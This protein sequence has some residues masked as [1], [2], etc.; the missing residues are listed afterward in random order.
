M[1]GPLIG[2]AGA[3]SVGG[4]L[5]AMLAHKGARVAFLGRRTFVDDATEFG[6]TATNFDGRLA[7]VPAA[8][9]VASDDPAILAGAD[10][11]LVTV[12][13]GDTEEMAET[14]A[15]T[16]S[17]HATLVSFQNG[18]GNGRILQRALPEHRVYR[19]SVPY[20]VISLG[21][22]QYRRAS[23]GN[24]VLDHGAS[25]IAPILR[26]AGA[27][28]LTADIEGVLWGKLLMNLNNALNALADA[29]LQEQLSNQAWRTRL[30]QMQNEA[31]LAMR[32]GGIVPKAP[33]ALP[34]R[35]F[36]A[37]LRLPTALFKLVAGRTITID[38][39]AR[40]SMWED[41][42]KGRATE[43]DALQ[44]EVIRLAE[45]AGTNADVCRAVVAAIKKA[46]N[47][48]AG[49]PGLSPSDI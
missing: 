4:Y 27:V 22:G 40:S 5:G 37:I 12:K 13:S 1:D 24:I 20:N 39:S 9:V 31:L 14:L 26:L 45:Q 44:G 28:D 10:I 7:T 36:P 18:V 41:L 19:G 23:S 15:R 46:E 11:V 30:A 6:L 38:P 42:K 25:D 2:I 47:E 8:N 43:I 16:V 32:A 33:V 48:K 21:R 35:L 3:G 34:A 49:P 17:S 29:P